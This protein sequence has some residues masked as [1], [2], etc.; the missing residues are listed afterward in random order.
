[1]LYL[2][3]GKRGGEPTAAYEEDPTGLT[4]KVNPQIAHGSGSLTVVPPTADGAER[5]KKKRKTKAERQAA[6]VARMVGSL[7]GNPSPSANAARADSPHP[8]KRGQ[9]YNTTRE[10]THTCVSCL[11]RRCLPEFERYT[12][13]FHLN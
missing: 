13:V 10:G 3:M 11:A 12:G 8:K 2:A 7:R 5:E 9:F 1:M 4:S 6:A